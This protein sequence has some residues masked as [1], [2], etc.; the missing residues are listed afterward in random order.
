MSDAGQ[1][2]TRDQRARSTVFEGVTQGSGPAAGAGG[3]DTTPDDD[4]RDAGTGGRRVAR[5]RRSERARGQTTLDFAVGVSL[6][7]IVFISVFIFV[8]GTL[9]P[10]AEGGQEE[11]VSANRV[12]DSLSESVLG[13]PASPHVLN[14]TCTV[15]F[16]ELSSPPS[17][18]AFAGT[19][20]SERIGVNDRQLANVTIRANLSK[21]ASGPEQAIL[22]WDEDDGPH[23]RLV[24]RDTAACDSSETQLRVGPTP[25]SETGTA[26]RARRIVEVNGTDATLFVEL[27]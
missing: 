26:V 5:E 18:C 15:A 12:A 23:P 6:F 16:F 25:P 20:I 9:Q 21:D 24:E 13:D 17:H 7:L 4:A 3:T 1:V 22:C 27:W 14:T 19:D 10:F 8:P 11:I 2:S